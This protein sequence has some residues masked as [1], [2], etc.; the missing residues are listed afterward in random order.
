MCHFYTQKRK[1][2]VNFVC[3]QRLDGKQEQYLYHT[4]S[5]QSFR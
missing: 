5:V 3:K 1:R 2:V 4:G